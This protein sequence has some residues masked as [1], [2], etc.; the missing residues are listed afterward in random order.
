MLSFKV[1]NLGRI[2]EADFT[3]APLTI[4][5]GQNNTGK[6]YLASLIWLLAKPEVAPFTDTKNTGVKWLDVL[7]GRFEKDGQDAVVKYSVGQEQASQCV[8]YLQSLY[9]ERFADLLRRLFSYEGFEESSIQ[10]RLSNEFEPF[11]ISIS[12]TSPGG[13]D[14]KLSERQHYVLVKFSADGKTL[15][16]FRFPSSRKYP[17]NLYIH[18]VLFECAA[19]ALFGYDWPSYRS[20]VYIPAARTGLML[21]MRSLIAERLD[22]DTDRETVLPL[23][24][25]DFVSTFIRAGAFA[26]KAKAPVAR[27]LE[28]TVLNG[29]LNVGEEEIPSFTYVPAHSS[30]EVPLHAT[31]SM[32]TEIAPFI[33]LIKYNAGG[34]FI[35]EEPEAHLH[36][37]AQ[38]QMAR[39]IARLLNDGAKFTIT[40]HSDTF[41]QQINNLMRLH[42]HPDREALLTQYGYDENDVIDPNR[43]RAY[44]FVQ[45]SNGTKITEL[46]RTEEGFVVPSLNETL[47]SLT[48][49]TIEFNE[50]E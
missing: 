15:R 20:P 50:D 22:F 39:A 27:W 16:Q 3:A 37:S 25:A 11:D 10:L 7:I 44:E 13:G 9:Q 45:T 29:T 34:H 1:K 5:V 43:T 21:T 28:D 48:Q 41:I 32:I 47:I 26:P 17:R 12:R 30:R 24:I 14:A 46:N 4:L 2:A 23:P 38:R 8:E 36:L 35:F 18:R 6:S 33:H 49:E 31:S 42:G 19:L 40:T